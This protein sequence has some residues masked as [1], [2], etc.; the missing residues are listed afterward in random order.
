MLLPDVIRPGLKVVFCGTALGTKSAQAEAYYAGPGN[1]FWRTLFEVGLTP[2]IL[3]SEEYQTLL[4][5]DLGLTDICKTDSGSDQEVGI[6]AFDVPRL[7]A[8]ISANKP[9]W[10]AFNGKN[11]ARGALETEVEY[12]VQ[13]GRLGGAR[14]FVLPSTSGAARGYWDI[15]RWREL[16]ELAASAG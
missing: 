8:Q 13:Q 10:I 7:I 4:E 6:H 16:A 15:E 3:R 1:S 12:G 2:R 11:A 5:H 14:V 9:R